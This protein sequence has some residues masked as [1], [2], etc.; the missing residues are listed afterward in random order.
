M[1]LFVGVTTLRLDR[2]PVRSPNSVRNIPAAQERHVSMVEDAT[3]KFK[4]RLYMI[5]FIVNCLFFKMLIFNHACYGCQTQ[6]DIRFRGRN[7]IQ[8][9]LF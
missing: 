6:Q 8:Y 3:S 1:L 9:C 5:M 4:T 2:K 7:I